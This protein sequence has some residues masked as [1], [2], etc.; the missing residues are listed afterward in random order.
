MA[1]IDRQHDRLGHLVGVQLH[2]PSLHRRESLVRRLDDRERLGCGERGA[3]PGQYNVC[4]GAPN[5]ANS[6]PAFQTMSQGQ[7][8][9]EFSGNWLLFS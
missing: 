7:L 3:V 4:Q 1:V 6:F 9:P 5:R 8:L 2:E